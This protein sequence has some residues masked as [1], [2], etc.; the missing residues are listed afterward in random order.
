VG[1]GSDHQ[2]A[3]AKTS[4]T[5]CVARAV[6]NAEMPGGSRTRLGY[7]PS[8]VTRAPTNQKVCRTPNQRVTFN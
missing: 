4:G 3:I 2:P 5:R 7:K 1:G 6:T 8:A